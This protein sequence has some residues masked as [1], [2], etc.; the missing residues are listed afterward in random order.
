MG[1]VVANGITLEVERHGPADAPAMVMIRGLGSQL[2]HWPD[3]LIGSFVAAGFHVVTFDNRDSGL[4][5]KFADADAYSLRDMAE[6]TV[7]LMDALGLRAA[8]VFGTS[9]GGMIAQLMALHHPARL[10]TVTIVMS[11]SRAPGLPQPDAEMQRMLR[12]PAPS[13]RRADVIAHELWSGRGF[14]SPRWP[15]DAQERAELIGR[16]YDR[17]HC[18]DGTSRQYKAMMAASADLADI[19]AISVPALILHGTDDRLLTL[20]HG[21]DIAARIP[22]ARLQEIEGMGHDL[23]GPPAEICARHVIDFIAQAHMPPPL[24]KE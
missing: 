1:S 13:D 17:C 11:S 22:G 14:Q 3:A 4:S 6:D 2:I 24:H 20:P 12:A 23:T 7:G 9:M 16:A 10:H 15:F 8:H 18:P 21:R 5:Q 19:E